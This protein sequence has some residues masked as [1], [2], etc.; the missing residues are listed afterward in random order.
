[1]SGLDK[2]TRLAWQAR[3]ALRPAV[4]IMQRAHPDGKLPKQVAVQTMART[5]ATSHSLSQNHHTMQTA[6]VRLTQS[7]AVMQ[8]AAVRLTQS[9]AVMRTLMSIAGLP[10]GTM[11]VHTVMPTVS[12][13]TG[14]A[15]AAVAP[16]L[17][18][19]QTVKMTARHASGAEHPALRAEPTC[20]PMPTEPACDA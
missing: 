1:M 2:T 13:A 10:T 19:N 4:A 7:Q 8:T 14:L 3:Q 5:K 15:E 17:S 12:W 18:V 20:E 9:Q 6:A 11:A 16:G